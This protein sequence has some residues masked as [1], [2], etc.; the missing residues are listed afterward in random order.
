MFP[1]FSEGRYKNVG[2]KRYKNVIS[3]DMRV[4]GETLDEVGSFQSIREQRSQ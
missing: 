4:N 2:M 1:R 3:V